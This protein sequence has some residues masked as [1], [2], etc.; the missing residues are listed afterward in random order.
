M[1]TFTFGLTIAGLA[2]AAPCTIQQTTTLGLA[3]I[4]TSTCDDIKT[5]DAPDCQEG[6]QDVSTSLQANYGLCVQM[7]HA[8]WLEYILDQAGQGSGSGDMG[9]GDASGSGDSSEDCVGPDCCTNQQKLGLFTEI[10]AVQTCNDVSN[11]QPPNCKDAPSMSQFAVFCNSM[12][13]AQFKEYIASEIDNIGPDNGDGKSSGSGG[14]GSGNGSGSG[15]SDCVGPDCCTDQQKRDVYKD[16]EQVEACSDVTKVQRPNCKDAPN[17]EKFAGY[18]ATVGL[19]EFR[20]KAKKEIEKL[21]G[22][23]APSSPPTKPPTS[24]APGVKPILLALVAP[25]L[26]VYLML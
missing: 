13:L 6:G 10:W 17:M 21:S 2:S 9:S 12:G 4:N 22:N 14:M 18:C 8:E 23:N 15:D 26:A 11:I 7:G 1:K 16:F 24:A 19:A 3:I 5:I 20:A 25:L